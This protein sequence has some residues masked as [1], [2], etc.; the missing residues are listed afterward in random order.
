MWNPSEKQAKEAFDYGNDP[1]PDNYNSMNE[2]GKRAFWQYG[3]S[4]GIFNINTL[5]PKSKAEYLKYVTDDIPYA[6]DDPMERATLARKSE[7]G[8]FDVSEQ[9]KASKVQDRRLLNES[10][11]EE[12]TQKPITQPKPP[13]RTTALDRSQEQY[14]EGKTFKK[15]DAILSGIAKGAG[16]VLGKLGLNKLVQN[17]GGS[18]IAGAAIDT[19][20]GIME[21]DSG[22]DLAKR[23]G[24]GVVIGLGADIG[25]GLIGKAVSGLRAGKLAKIPI[26]EVAAAKTDLSPNTKITSQGKY[27][28][29]NTALDKAIGE[30]NKAIETIQNHFQTNELRVDEMA[31]IKTELGIDLDAI[32][33]NME[34]A[35]KGVSI[36]GIGARRNLSNAAGVTDLPKIKNNA[37]KQP[38]INQNTASNINTQLTVKNAP[39]G[40]QKFKV[41]DTEY[42]TNT[43]VD[44]SNKTVSQALKD[45]DVY[46]EIVK[47]L[48]GIPVRP[49]ENIKAIAGRIKDKSGMT[50]NMKD[51][52]RNLRDAFGENY[53]YVKKNYLDALDKSKSEY[54]DEVKAYTDN[55]YNKVVKGLG[56]KKDSTESAAV[57]WLGEG[58]KQV[59]SELAVDPNTGKKI[60]VPKLIDYTEADLIKEFGEPTAKRIKEAE[61]IFRQSYDE[62]LE[63]VNA[64]RKQIY[65]NNAEKLVPARKDYYHHFREMQDSFEGIKNM[66]STPSQIDPRLAGIS[67]FTKP[68]S[69]WAKF[70]QQRGAG[71]YKADAVGGFLEYIQPASYAIHIDPHISRFRGLAKD[72]A[73]STVD[74]RNANN[75]IKYL[76]DF[77][78]NLA[79]KTNKYDR[80]WQEDLPGGRM[81][82]R[83]VNW[84]NNR[85]KKNQ[86]LLNARSAVSQLANVPLGIAKIK[87]PIHITQGIGD[88]L[89]SV[90]KSYKANKLYA[91]S[92][93]LKE[94]YSHDLIG[95]FEER[96]FKQPEKFAGWVL[97]VADEMGT[98]FI[99]NSSYRQA[100]AQG[101]ENPIKHADEITRSLVAG[102]GIAEVPL[103]QQSK[104]FQIVAPFQLEVA[105]MWH[106]M[107][108]MTKEKDFGGILA[109]MI[110]NYIFNEGAEE[111]TGSRVT[112]DPINAME[113]ALSEDDTNLFQKGYNLLA[114]GEKP[115]LKEDITPLNVGGRL[116]GE[117]LSNVPFGQTIASTF[118][119]ENR[120]TVTLPT[121]EY[122]V[123]GRNELFGESDP[124]RFGSGLLVAK[125]L[126]N[127]AYKIAP[128]LGGAQA[129][130]TIK[131]LKAVNEKG[132]Y[133]TTDKG[134]KLRYPVENSK[135]NKAKAALFGKYALAESQKYFRGNNLPLSENQTK[136]F[137]KRVANGENPQAVY[138]DMM[139]QRKINSLKN[140]LSEVNK[141][142][143]LTPSERVNERA[144]INEQINKL[145]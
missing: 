31:K 9:V 110:G 101:I 46:S 132:D 54:V 24:R 122:S 7:Q 63:K 113:E 13:I 80:L 55:V 38:T 119:P 75:T 57:Q 3:K 28:V 106:V 52:W 73:E 60:R 143:K 21:G 86:V 19:T 2:I 68:Q 96:M 44:N 41:G 89:A 108:D 8:Q 100:V 118:I 124:T 144:K 85:V 26:P 33:K 10:R 107:G 125:G 6:S 105:N 20:Q 134:K 25:L 115:T 71:R 14:S 48:D 109:I 78:N 87:N 34:D 116:G 59:G 138:D 17:L 120:S 23:V 66:F 65:P 92:G 82:F 103:A 111:L 56:I 126:A 142:D 42:D 5:G 35:E 70:M 12:L 90:N 140:K 16:T 117:V 98:K 30:Y 50:L 121:G 72:I 84:L 81:T 74:T 127:P 18:A 43:F 15:S 83:A 136:E 40:N 32:V 88:T 130:K 93:F 123:P 104:I 37:L 64:V 131:G 27:K 141:N 29:K 76:N 58:K 139:K 145:K 135:G 95:R 133:I 114:K 51:A 102:R 11:L 4:K 49:D 53:G 61:A 79:G 45:D 22:K 137:E 36:S 112:F 128:P 129:E 77:A 94:R 91:Q 62:L 47:E 67:E 99:W 97:G 1:N 39:K 69:K